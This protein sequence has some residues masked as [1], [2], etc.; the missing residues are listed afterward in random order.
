M[1]REKF[2]SEIWRPYP[3]FPQG[4]ETS[5][6][7]RFYELAALPMLN[8]I[9]LAPCRPG[10]KSLVISKQQLQTIL[11]P[12]DWVCVKKSESHISQIFL[13]APALQEPLQLM[14]NPDIQK[15]WFEFLD[16]V[17][18]FF[19]QKKFHQ[20]QTP[21][22]VS[23]PGTEP[24][25]DLFSTE[26]LVAGKKEKVY[27]TT[28]PEIHLKKMLSS[29]YRNIFEIKN[30]F[31]N[32]EIS[33]RH[34]PE[35]TML[36][37]Y[38]SFV[39]LDQIQQDCLDLIQFLGGDPQGFQRKSMSELFQEMLDFELTPDTGILELKSL[40]KSLGLSVH[41]FELWDD[42]FYFIFIEK[43]EPFLNS[44][45]PLFVEKYPPSQAAFS[46]LT[47]DGWGDRFEIYWQGLEIGNA[48][49]ELNDPTIQE[50]RFREDLDKKLQLGKEAPPLDPQFRQ[51]LYAGMPPSSGIAVGLERL[52]MALYQI[53]DIHQIKPF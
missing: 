9:E 6:A 34:R 26:M 52:F 41:D 53:K 24:F 18:G 20:A 39:N 16:Q 28:S 11:S 42:V 21:T 32:G 23:C 48:F 30:C 49:H 29:G 50:Q 3:S 12:N 4:Y 37:W 27:L 25:L 45:R 36:E 10:Q 47:E 15:K 40:G 14:S 33:Q 51:A 13:L 5:L 7:A 8:Q 46:R 2:L 22:L 19:T 31:R 17:R 43:I 38:R 35:F 1:T 44:K